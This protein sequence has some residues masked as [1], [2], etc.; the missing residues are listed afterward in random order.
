[1]KASDLPAIA[2]VDTD[3]DYLIVVDRSANETKK[4]VPSQ[5]SMPEKTLNVVHFGA[6]PTGVNDS[7]AAIN[8]AI[9]AA[10]TNAFPG[11][12]GTSVF[13]PK[14]S[15]KISSTIVVD[16]GIILHGA[17][18]TGWLGGTKLFVDDGIHGIVVVNG[19]AD[20]YGD[21]SGAW[22]TIRD[23]LV[24]GPGGMFARPSGGV[25]NKH[26]VH[27]LATCQLMGV[28]VAGFTGNGF[29][30]V[31]NSGVLGNANCCYVERC[32]GAWNGGH[33]IYING[34]DANASVWVACS[35]TENAGWGIYDAS[36][37]GNAHIGHHSSNN[38]TGAYKS[39]GGVNTSTWIGCYSEGGQTNEFDT[40]ADVLGGQHGAPNYGTASAGAQTYLKT[41]SFTRDAGWGTQ[42]S[43]STGYSRGDNMVPSLTVFRST[44]PVWY[45]CI[46]A[47]TS[48]SSEPT[49]TA[50]PGATMS[51][52]SVTW[53]CM[54]FAQTE[55]LL[56]TK[57]VYGSA[58]ETSAFTFTSFDE[59][60]HYKLERYRRCWRLRW[61]GS[62]DNAAFFLGG[63]FALPGKGGFAVPKLYTAKAEAWSDPGRR[64]THAAAIPSTGYWRRGDVVWSTIPAAGGAPGWVCVTSGQSDAA[65]WAANTFYAVGS[66]IEPATPNGYVYVCIDV[67]GT[68]SSGTSGSSTPT[69]P[70]TLDFTVADGRLT[71]V[72]AGVDT[73]PTFKAMAN[74]AA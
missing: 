67:I 65:S 10:G 70:T 53:L 45:R 73:G 20:G 31:A 68:Q 43:A 29:N 16:R 56:G 59:A 38:V 47:G 52:G 64:L 48:G 62:D 18:G 60:A 49:W 37:L 36:S 30:N 55:T 26:G 46:T 34:S 57:D 42:W 51:D 9:H 27:M 14:G 41:Q 13:I 54:G 63:A 71:W 19:P 1:M 40:P 3:N 6:D 32:W 50:T 15:Y 24:I 33:G 72:C 17:S 8:A 23:L 58:N 5:L 61:G 35:A 7:A 21:G 25:A 11:T 66:T 12:G 28:Y 44:A 74:L 39:S 22:S 4:A 69:W 2:Q